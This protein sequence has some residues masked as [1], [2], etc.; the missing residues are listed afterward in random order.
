ML[1]LNSSFK[2]GVFQ[3]KLVSKELEKY[4]PKTYKTG[5]KSWVRVKPLQ[6]GVHFNI[7]LEQGDE[8]DKLVEEFGKI[9]QQLKV[10]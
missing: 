1:K 7:H 2:T 5:K 10:K 4:K 8:P 6:R 9:I 3:W